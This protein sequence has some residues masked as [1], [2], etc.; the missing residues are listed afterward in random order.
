MLL[1]RKLGV[2]NHQHSGYIPRIK[3]SYGSL[4]ALAETYRR[5]GAGAASPNNLQAKAGRLTD[6]GMNGKRL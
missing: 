2:I 3:P 1:R 6:C 5:D 4:V